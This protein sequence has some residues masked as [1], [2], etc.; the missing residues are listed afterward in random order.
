MHSDAFPFTSYTIV[1]NM[2]DMHPQQ[3]SGTCFYVV[4]LILDSSL[5]LGLFQECDKLGHLWQLGLHMDILAI[6]I[7]K[8]SVIHIEYDW[9]LSKL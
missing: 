1:Y 3:C 6:L 4:K 9:E 5:Y 8:P 2:F 7:H